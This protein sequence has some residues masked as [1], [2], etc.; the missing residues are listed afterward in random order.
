MLFYK[1]GFLFKAD[2]DA[3]SDC[4]IIEVLFKVTGYVVSFQDK[5]V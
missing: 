2:S 4:K 3:I 1:P 5:Q